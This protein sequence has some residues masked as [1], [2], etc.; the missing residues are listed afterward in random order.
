MG[1]LDRGEAFCIVGVVVGLAY[2]RVGWADVACFVA[3]EGGGV[4]LH[5]GNCPWFGV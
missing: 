2:Q 5:G 3:L 1:G 4:S